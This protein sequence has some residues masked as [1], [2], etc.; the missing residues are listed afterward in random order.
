MVYMAKPPKP[1]NPNIS[2]RARNPVSHD[3]SELNPL[4]WT[5][6]RRL[7]LWVLVFA[8]AAVA[9]WAYADE[10]LMKNGSRLLGTVVSMGGEK[11][12]FKTEFAG[13]IT[14]DWKQVE[15]LTTEGPMEVQLEDGTEHKGKAVTAEEGRIVLQD[16]K[17]APSRPISLAE[18]KSVN[19]EKP[20]EGWQFKGRLELGLSYE[21]GNTSND[22]VDFEGRLDFSRLHHA[23]TLYV[24]SNMEKSFG[25]K[26]KDKSLFRLTYRRFLTEKIYLFGIAG[27]ER[28]YFSDMLLLG[29]GGAGAGYQFW[30]SPEK[31]FMVYIGPSYVQ[32]KY[33]EPQQSLGYRDEQDYAAALCGMD[34]DMWFFKQRLQFFHRNTGTWSLEDSDVWRLS[35]RTGFRVPMGK[36]FFTTLQYN[37]DYVNAPADGKLKADKEALIRVGWKW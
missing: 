34:F 35:T 19:P 11:L 4:K 17:E 22:K 20:P 29:L 30:K 13:E 10:V 31:N 18:V 7:C 26:T 36:F 21:S 8:L 12:I 5:C 6:P 15:L 37:Y 33:S 16:K 3:P 27:A 2:G 25:E 1:G 28:D 23:F 24:E 14:I 32:E 9:N